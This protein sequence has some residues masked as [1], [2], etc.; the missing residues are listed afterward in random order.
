MRRLVLL[1][2]LL[3]PATL[4]LAAEEKAAAEDDPMAGWAPRKVTKDAQD[5]KEITAFFKAMDEAGKKGDLAA[6]A[7]LVDFPVLMVTDDS[8]G[9]AHGDAWSQEQWEKVMS[10]F[11]EKPMTDMKMT[12]KP[13]VF[14]ISDS[15][16]SVDDVYTMTMGK[17]TVT[18]RS[19]MLLVR[20]DGKWRVKAMVESGWG[21]MMAAGA[22]EGEPP[23]GTAGSKTSK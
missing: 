19:S 22:P 21:D 1:C 9:Q 17:K 4:A 6:A 23:Q 8:K 14:L 13:T 3:V 16:A 18:S 2:T 11:Y 15:L 5:R 12:H 20:K 7:A 10:P